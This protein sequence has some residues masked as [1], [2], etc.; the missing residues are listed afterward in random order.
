MSSSPQNS[1]P[2][3]QISI[4]PWLTVADATTAVAFYKN[5]FHA[6]ETY[7]LEIP[8]GGLV[9]K[10]AIGQAE[11]WVSSA[12]D[13]A[14]VQ[15]PVGGSTVRMILTVNNPDELF[16]SATSAGA[17]EIFPVGE[18]HGW[19]LGRIED[20]FGLHWEIGHPLL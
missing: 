8:G 17:K 12:E 4:A 15:G 9:A 16:A 13:A 3:I 18:S 6:V 7:R 11:F 5:A 10:L 20:P 19:R 14:T 2:A 1:A